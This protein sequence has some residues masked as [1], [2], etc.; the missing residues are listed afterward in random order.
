[1]P[2]DR[3]GST[4]AGGVAAEHTEALRLVRDA[5]WPVERYQHWLA[6]VLLRLFLD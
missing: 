3:S 2:T 5:G 6:D 1:M 4:G